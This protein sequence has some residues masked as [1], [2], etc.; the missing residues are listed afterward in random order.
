MRTIALDFDGVIC[1]SAEEL[2]RSSWMGN[3]VLNTG[4]SALDTVPIDF[5]RRFIELRPVIHTG[6]EGILLAEMIVNDFDDTDIRSDF[7]S[8]CSQLAARFRVEREELIEM[9]GAARDRWID[10]DIDGWIRTHQFYPGTIDTI[11]RLRERMVDLAIITTKEKRFASRLLGPFDLRVSEDRVF[12]LAEGT[13][14]DVLL[15]LS[16]EAPATA[17]SII[18]I[19]DRLET[20]E[21]IRDTTGLEM[22]ELYL[23]SWGYNSMEQRKRA[24]ADSR[25]NVLSL[26]EFIEWGKNKPYRLPSDSQTASLEIQ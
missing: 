7:S 22:V 2:A 24:E 9:F 4:K 19:D 5:I 23:A 20:L 21:T 25:I 3:Q 6:F 1:D 15:R 12:G 8:L 11:K 10:D 16:S 18:F 17:G 14:S 13:K 26:G